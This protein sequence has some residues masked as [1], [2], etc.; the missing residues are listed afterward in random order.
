MGPYLW[1][2]IGIL[3]TY[4]FWQIRP[5]E[6]I[7]EFV[8]WIGCSP[9]YQEF[10]VD[11]LLP[12]LVTGV[13][14]LV[15]LGHR[16]VWWLSKNNLSG[17][18]VYSLRRDDGSAERVALCHVRHR[19]D[20]L[21]VLYGRVFEGSRTHADGTLIEQQG[22]WTSN[23]GDARSSAE[24][25]SREVN[26]L[27]RVEMPHEPPPTAHPTIQADAKDRV[28]WGVF[29][30]FSEERVLPFGV[31]CMRGRYF[32][33]DHRSHIKGQAFF[34]RLHRIHDGNSAKDALKTHRIWLLQRVQSAVEPVG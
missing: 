3:G 19:G 28:W 26:I 12:V 13:A 30:L 5:D 24:A 32:D 31:G 1:A 8:E 34:V 33:V 14:Y 7:R 11:V 16:V 25:D 4:A 27:F 6:Q 22:S 21:Q 18:W 9:R 15:L 2:L 20:S 29:R 17:W 23:A 10:L